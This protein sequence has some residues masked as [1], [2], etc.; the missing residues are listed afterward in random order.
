MYTDFPERLKPTPKRVRDVL[1]L[2]PDDRLLVVVREEGDGVA[3][4]D[5]VGGEGDAFGKEADFIALTALHFAD[6]PLRACIIDEQI[7][8]A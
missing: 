6:V 8:T 2:D 3:V 7:A 5:V 1:V 4:D